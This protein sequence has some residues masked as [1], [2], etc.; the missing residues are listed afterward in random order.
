MDTPYISRVL[1]GTLQ[2]K[3]ACKFFNF[4]FDRI[5]NITAVL[6]SWAS[7]YYGSLITNPEAIE[8]IYGYEMTP[9]KTY[10]VYVYNNIGNIIFSNTISNWT[11]SE[12]IVLLSQESTEKQDSTLMFFRNFIQRIG[13][14]SPTFNTIGFSSTIR[15]T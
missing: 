12:N 1:K 5:M 13:V 8:N 4:K 15:Y 11:A 3:I 7:F 9:I 14:I 2:F 10:T 6:S